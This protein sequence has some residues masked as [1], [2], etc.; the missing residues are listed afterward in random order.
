MTADQLAQQILKHKNLYYA[1]KPIISDFEF[2]ELEEQ[3]R[4][5][6]PDHPVLKMVG[7]EVKSNKKIKHDK[8][9]LSL[10]KTYSEKDLLDWAQKDKIVSTFKIDGS[11]CSLIYEDGHL[12]LGKTRGD[13]EF[14]ED[15][16]QKVWFLD[17]I[18]KKISL[19]DKI[20]IRGEIFCQEEQFIKLAHEMNKRGLEKPTSQRNIVAGL[21]GRKE[22]IDLSSYLTF[23]AFE[24]FGEIEFDTEKEKLEKLKKLNFQIPDYQILKSEKEIKD[25]I[26]EARNF[27]SEGDYLIDGLVFTYNDLSLHSDLG[28]TAHHPRY[29][30]AFKFQGESKV[31]EIKT[32]EWGVSR[33][34]ILTP[35]AHIEPVSLSGAMIGR[36]TLH[37]YGMVNEFK[38]KT[39]DKIEIVRSGEVIPKFISVV[40]SSKNKFKIPANCPSCHKP[41]FEEDIRLICKNP[42]C[43]DKI[44]DEILNFI[45]KIGI[46]DLSDKRL[47]EMIRVGL[48]TDISSLYDLSVDDLMTLDKTKEKLANKIYQNIQNSKKTTL[49]KF[50]SS[51]GITGGAINKNER[52]INAGH[53]TIQKIKKLSVS[54]L[55]EIEGF[56]EK[57]S[58][59]YLSSLKTKLDLIDSLI[60]KGFQF[61][62]IQEN[63]SS[64]LE[65]LKFCITGT[66]TRKRSDIQ[67]DIKANGGEAQSGVTSKTN[68]LVTNDK[69]STSSK[70]KKALELNIPIIT[71]EELYEKIG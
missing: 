20:E 55:Q 30:L 14:G 58:Q 51:L 5:L 11:S 64:K 71:E 25:V 36:V 33:N 1:G 2:D 34:G 65:G 35:V 21:L 48:V 32:I 6:D 70:F 43:P 59:D 52:I 60:K 68:Y 19:R 69:D 16:T 45:R 27:M 13:G 50:M 9:M 67:K 37:N 66:L 57:S 41:I 63:K 28:Y 56:A 12:A 24:I 42:S 44:K 29:K 17:S 38:L 8:K 40:E 15:I 7:A 54:K 23:Y 3:L 10:G 26:E 47:A 46:D 39:G 18:P 61:E 49:L 53:N 4:K 31:A 22:N 62:K